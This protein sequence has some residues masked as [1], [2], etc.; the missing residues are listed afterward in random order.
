M[1][2]IPI[3]A[4]VLTLLLSVAPVL[5]QNATKAPA[6][7]EAMGKPWASIVVA[8][9]MMVL[10]AVPSFLSAKRGHQD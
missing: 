3:P 6:P 4:A 7:K 8:F 10:I 5:A 2:W 1:K 9:F